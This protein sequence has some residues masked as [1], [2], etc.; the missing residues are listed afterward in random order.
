MSRLADWWSERVPVS[1]AQL[2]ELTNEPVPNHMKKWWFCL[3]GTPAYLF[4]VQIITGIMLAIY[5][6]PS[7]T[8]A[9][10]SVRHITEEVTFGWYFRGLHKWAA[11]LM[12]ASVVLHQMRVYFTA[13]YRRPRELNWII[14]MCLLMVTL[15]L[16]FTGYSLVFEQ[17]SY[18]GA[19]VGGN[20]MDTVPVV[21]GFFKAVLL[22]GETYNE[23][24]LPRFYILHAAIMPVSLILLIIV[25]IAFIRIHGVTELEEPDQP[26]D[27]PKHFNFFPDHLL[28]ELALGLVLM[29]LLSTLATIFPAELGPR[30]DPLTTPEVIKPEWFFYATFRWLKLFGPT[31]AV[32]SMG[33]IVFLMFIWP[34][35]DRWLIRVTRSKEASTYI[36]IVAVF[37]I[38]SLTVWE[39]AVAH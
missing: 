14:G 21:G 9:Y 10:E 29:I 2:R 34:W 8:T 27:K 23:Q 28:T 30:A 25:H 15:G 13:A 35:V 38:I 1:G 36:G 22:A 39:A 5:Y 16:G 26:V 37:L 31:F 32:L 24:T 19:T 6:Q 11:T 4:V 7:S 20:I 3:G 33:L 12:I 18:W 17:L